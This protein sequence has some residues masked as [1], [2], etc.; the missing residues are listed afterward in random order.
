MAHENSVLYDMQYI[1]IYTKSKTFTA[2]ECPKVDYINL[3]GVAKSTRCL[4][5]LHGVANLHGVYLYSAE[6][7][8]KNSVKR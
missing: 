3:H 7:K 8:L 6:S 1:I 2:I 5:N 4:L